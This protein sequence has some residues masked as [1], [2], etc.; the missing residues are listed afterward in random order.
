MARAKAL[1]AGLVVLLAIAGAVSAAS[2]PSVTITS[3]KPGSTFSARRTPNLPLTGNVAFADSSPN[4]TT[5]YLRRDACGTSNDNPHL[6]ISFDPSKP[7]GGDGCGWVSGTGVAPLASAT[8]FSV[9]FPSTDGMP[10]AIDAS[11]EAHGV[12]TMQSSSADGQSLGV[13]Q[14]TMDFQLEALVNGSGVTV[15]T[16]S[17]TVTIPVAGGTTFQ[18]PFTIPVDPSLDQ[19]DVA[20]LDLHLYWHG[21]YAESGYIHTSGA[22]SVT[23][24]SFAAS[25]HKAV[26]ASI[27][28]PTF[29]SPIATA[30]NGS[31]WSVVVPTPAV[32]THTVYVRATQGFDTSATA[33][34]SFT[35]KR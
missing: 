4:E 1:V 30:L 17:E 21:P 20:G 33:T 12:I 35:V 18:V 13:G 14:V 27:D 7:D 16:D 34:S 10:V 32:G 25:V 6:S 28:D 3:P 26:Q 15:G 11:R 5:F 31:T 24:P 8:L 9:D 22:S 29:A 2:T 19:V 23:V